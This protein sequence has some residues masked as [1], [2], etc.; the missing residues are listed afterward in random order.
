MKEMRWKIAGGRREMKIELESSEL[1]WPH[2][3]TRG[4]GPPSSDAQ[5]PQWFT[6]QTSPSLEDNCFFAWTVYVSGFYG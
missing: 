5:R 4:G 6:G 2:Y 3:L 1:E